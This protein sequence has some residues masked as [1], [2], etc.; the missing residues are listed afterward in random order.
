MSNTI[1]NT[2]TGTI[3]STRLID[4]PASTL[5]KAFSNPENLK[6][7]WGP[8]GFANT[9]H[10]F[11]FK[12][13]GMWTFSMHGPDGTDYPNECE[14]K[15][16]VE[17]KRIVFAHFLPVHVF[18]M[19]LGFETAGDKTKFSFTMVFEDPTEVERIKQ[20]VVPANEENF[21]RLENFVHHNLKQ[22][23]FNNG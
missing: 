20:F 19:T 2:E 7:W 12:P 3:I 9:I 11:E 18:T 1:V 8:K 22:H 21:D 16:I 14:F 23:D 17:N 4:T 13:G 6:H 15:E 10:A 5:F